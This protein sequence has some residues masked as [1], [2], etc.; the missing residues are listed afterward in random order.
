[1]NENGKDIYAQVTAKIV[2]DL[3]NGV[4]SWNQPWTNRGGGEVF[5][6]VRHNGVAYRGVNVFLLWIEAMRKGFSSP[7]WM[8]YH[9]AQQMGGQPRHIPSSSPFAARDGFSQWVAAAPAGGHKACRTLSRNISMH[10]LINTQRP[11]ICSLLHI[12]D[13]SPFYF[14]G[15][16][17]FDRRVTLRHPP[18][19]PVHHYRRLPG[20]RQHEIA[21]TPPQSRGAATSE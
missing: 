12:F 4:R 16:V 21:Q 15:A 19:S 11:N 14:E 20:R 8:T 18:H 1:M 9:Q 7:K 17:S 13:C 3:E 5:I 2:A 6:P 10:S